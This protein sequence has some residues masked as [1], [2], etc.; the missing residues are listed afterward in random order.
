MRKND[1]FLIKNRKN[2]S[3]LTINQQKK[4][5]TILKEKR[6]TK[7]NQKHTSNSRFRDM[8]QEFGIFTITQGRSRNS[9][10]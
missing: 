2:K 3:R 5:R 8:N 1:E 9:G 6:E 4:F 10:G 7:Y